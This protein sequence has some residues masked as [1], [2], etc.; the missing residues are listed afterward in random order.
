MIDITMCFEKTTQL[1][2]GNAL[3]N[4]IFNVRPSDSTYRARPSV[5]NHL[6][7][8]VLHQATPLGQS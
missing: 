6:S 8:L 5:R 2:K 4:D 1:I 7:T 3:T